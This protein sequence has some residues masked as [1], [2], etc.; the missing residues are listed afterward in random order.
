MR[1]HVY[2]I[3][4]YRAPKTS[5]WAPSNTAIRCEGCHDAVSPDGRTFCPDIGKS[6]QCHKYS[7]STVCS[8]SAVQS[9][10]RIKKQDALL[11]IDR[12]SERQH[13]KLYKQALK[14]RKDRRL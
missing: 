14:A 5:D 6:W 1:Q 7:Q 3:E 8:L 11:T 12:I 4:K 10:R 13:N 2:S 9:S